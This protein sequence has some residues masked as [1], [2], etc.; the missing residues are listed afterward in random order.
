MPLEKDGVMIILSSPSGAGKT[1]LVKMLSEIDNYEISYNL[2]KIKTAL[3]KIRN[4]DEKNLQDPYPL[5]VQPLATEINNLLEH[6]EKILDRAKTH[7][8]NLAHVL[9]TPLAVISNELDTKD[10][11]LANQIQLMKKQNLNDL[12]YF[13]KIHQ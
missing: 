12:F 2:D 1:T 5:E 9:K 4:G 10:K 8:G 7:V 6:N 3:F 13:L 11:T